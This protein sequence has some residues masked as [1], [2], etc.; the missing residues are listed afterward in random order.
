MWSTEANLVIFL[1]VFVIWH[2]TNSIIIQKRIFKCSAVDMLLFSFQTKVTDTKF[3]YFLLNLPPYRL[4]VLCLKYFC[5]R[6]C[7]YWWLEIK[8]FGDEMF[9]SGITF[10]TWNLHLEC[11]CLMVD[12]LLGL[13]LCMLHHSVLHQLSILFARSLMSETL[14][15]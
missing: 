5:L 6:S 11:Q 7:C 8:V 9:C 15:I 1:G 2:L 3:V 12:W 10:H 4:S 13:W 14:K